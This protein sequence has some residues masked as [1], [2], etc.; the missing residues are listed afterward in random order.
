M[1]IEE[2]KR[3]KERIHESQ[4]NTTITPN[5][6]RGQIKELPTIQLSRMIGN[7]KILLKKNS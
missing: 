3:W 5:N 6:S 7:N 1:K 4:H 2:Q